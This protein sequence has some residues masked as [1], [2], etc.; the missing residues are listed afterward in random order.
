[1]RKACVNSTVLLNRAACQM[2]HQC[3]SVIQT[4]PR[5]PPCTRCTHPQHRHQHQ[6][7]AHLAHLRP[8]PPRLR[9]LLPHLRRR[10]LP[11]PPPSPNP[12]IRQS[13]PTRRT[14]QR[15][16]PRR[17]LRLQRPRRLW[18]RRRSSA[19]RRAQTRR[20]PRRHRRTSRRLRNGLIGNAR[21]RARASGV[22][23]CTVHISFVYSLYSLCP[24]VLSVTISLCDS[25]FS[26]AVYISPSS[27]PSSLCIDISQLY[28][29]YRNLLFFS[30]V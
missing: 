6:C 4:V 20:P 26:H 1:M 22:A 25:L 24:S 10:S 14:P 21:G 27:H 13:S 8:V 9:T 23:V 5:Y 12:K 16:P 18:R 15:A 2:V 28:F 19:R 29:T 17:N 11:P 7:P 30:F 3:N